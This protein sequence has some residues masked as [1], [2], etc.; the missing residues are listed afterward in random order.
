MKEAGCTLWTAWGAAV[1][2]CRTLEAPEATISRVEG[3]V[4]YWLQCK[5]ALTRP[6]SR[7]TDMSMYVV[8]CDCANG[9]MSR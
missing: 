6:F 8:L 4:S 7:V 1:E 2:V 5:C 3:V 9:R